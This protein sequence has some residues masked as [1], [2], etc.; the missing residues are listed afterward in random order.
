MPATMIHILMAYKFDPQADASFYIGNFA[1]DAIEMRPGFTR[2][3]KDIIHYRNTADRWRA[4]RDLAK[5]TDPDN[6]CQEGF[7]MHLF[8]DACWDAGPHREYRKQHCPPSPQP[9][10]HEW[11]RNYRREI[12]LAGCWLY[13][14]KPWMKDVWERIMHES[15]DM[16]LPDPGPTEQEI[17]DFR[18]SVYHWHN[19]NRVGPSAFYLPEFVEEYT[20]QIVL[21]YKKWRNGNDEQTNDRIRGEEHHA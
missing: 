6:A 3:I 2:E 13:Y 19:Q 1:P 17:L 11:F 18:D 10:N 16:E 12:T 14:T 4:L 15:R 21:D 7:L 8:Y 20:D 5:K 9:H